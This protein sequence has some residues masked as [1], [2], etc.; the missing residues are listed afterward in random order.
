MSAIKPRCGRNLSFCVSV[1]ILVFGLPGS[2]LA[3]APPGQLNVQ[4]FGV[5]GS[6]FETTASTTA[7]SKQI[8]VADA[9][10]FQPG[11]GVVISKSRSYQDKRQLWGPRREITWAKEL[12]DKAELRGYDGSQGDWLVLILDVP[13]AAPHVFRWSEDFG[14]TWRETAPMTGQW[15]PL[16]DGMEVR[17]GKHDWES[18]YTVVFSCRGQLATTIEKIEGNAIT[19]RDAPARAGK[20]AMLAHRDDDALQAVIDRAIQEKKNV[21]IPVGHYRL[22][23]GL[24]VQRRR[25]HCHRGGRRRPNGARY[26]RG[27]GRLPNPEPGYGSQSSATSVS[28]DTRDS[29]AASNAAASPCSAPAI[30]GASRPNHAMRSAFRTRSAC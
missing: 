1:A 15:Q 5:S 28:W 8:V 19:L 25:R 17:F 9:G 13:P 4:D 26:Q 24:M 7:G 29:T 10:D 20:D 30:F 27:R 18:G 3:D 12:G 2:S 22:F 6:E 23:H 16:R 11:Q 21:Y 14:L